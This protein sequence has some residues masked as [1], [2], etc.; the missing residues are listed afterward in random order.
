MS[1]S[2]GGAGSESL[3]DLGLPEEDIRIYRQALRNGDHVVSVEVEDDD[4]L[5]RVQEIMRRPEDAYGLG[6]LDARYDDAE[7]IPHQLAAYADTGSMIQPVSISATDATDSRNADINQM[8]TVKVVE[9]R[10]KV[11]KREVEGGAL[12][13]RSYVREVLVEAEVDLRSTRVSVGR[14]PID[15]AVNPGDVPA[16]DRVH[17]AR[18]HVGEAVVAKEVRWSR[19]SAC[20]RRT[21]RKRQ[22]IHE[23]EDENERTRLSG[24]GITGSGRF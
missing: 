19:R 14:R 1:G 13:V 4:D 7:H 6:E 20:A 9:E 17:E 18:E 24:D 23:T 11:G 5:S 16:G 10:L 2:E 22:Q 8:G 12:R 21:T 15:R 3:Y